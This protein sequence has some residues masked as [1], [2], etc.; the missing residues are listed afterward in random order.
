RGRVAL[1]EA[2]QAD[3]HEPQLRH[4]AAERAVEHLVSVRDHGDLARGI[5]DAAE[6]WLPDARQLHALAGLRLPAPDA[7]P[8]ADAL[9]HAGQK[10]AAAL[11]VDETGGPHWHGI[12]ES[13]VADDAALADTLT[14]AAAE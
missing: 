8:L 11:I 3:E 9:H 7:Q 1:A 5:A 2:E 6:T 4:S 14:V 10:Q 12:A 13:F